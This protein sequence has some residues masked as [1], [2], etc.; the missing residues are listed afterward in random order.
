MGLT[1]KNPPKKP[2]KQKITHRLNISKIKA[3]SHRRIDVQ[4]AYQ[5]K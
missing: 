4:A 3:K 5:Y 2:N 1:I